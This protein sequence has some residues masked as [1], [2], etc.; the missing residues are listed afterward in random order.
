MGLALPLS[1]PGSPFSLYEGR[2]EVT[3]VQAPPWQQGWCPG[4]PWTQTGSWIIPGPLQ[5]APP[6]WGLL[7]YRGGRAGSCGVHGTLT[8]CPVCLWESC[9]FCRGAEASSCSSTV[10]CIIFSFLCREI[11]GAM[12]S[13][14][15]FSSPFP[16]APW[17]SACR[18]L[19]LSSD[20]SKSHL[21][22][23][24]C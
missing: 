22:P 21:Y 19:K 20:D 11:C 16:P 15:L 24:L 7:G 18:A 8:P 6:P 17:L 3:M 10:G 9:R 4:Y 12:S 5:A 14:G 2:A 1:G 23:R 13:P